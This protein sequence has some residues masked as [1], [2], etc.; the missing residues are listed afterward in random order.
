MPKLMMR[1]P[2]SS[3]NH[4]ALWAAKQLLKFDWKSRHLV[5]RRLKINK[6]TLYRKIMAIMSPDDALEGQATGIALPAEAVVI[7]LDKQRTPTYRQLT[8]HTFFQ[9]RR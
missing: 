3:T 1:L 7:L 4:S 5:V 6:E 8:L 2:A 9:K